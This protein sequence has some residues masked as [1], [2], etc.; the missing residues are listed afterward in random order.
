MDYI[1]ASNGSN[2]SKWNTI[3]DTYYQPSENNF[4][5]FSIRKAKKMQSA[6][7]T[8][9]TARAS[10]ANSYVFLQHCQSGANSFGCPIHIHQHLNKRCHVCIS[11]ASAASADRNGR[12]NGKWGKKSLFHFSFLY[13][14]EGLAANTLC[15]EEQMGSLQIFKIIS[16][17]SFLTYFYGVFVAMVANTVGICWPLGV[18]LPF[19]SFLLNIPTKL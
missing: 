12:R 19:S 5:Y 15:A 1:F 14:S 18:H 9:M 7:Q 11:R 4:K 17:L 2:K 6:W 3:L 13:F 10:A 8:Q 16:Y